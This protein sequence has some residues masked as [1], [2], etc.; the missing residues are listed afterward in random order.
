VVARVV[1]QR[2]FRLAASLGRQ[3]R[4]DCSTRTPQPPAMMGSDENLDDVSPMSDFYRAC[5]MRGMPLRY[6]RS[7][8]RYQRNTERYAHARRR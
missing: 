8:H 2:V 3:S 7:R 1:V 6:V 5:G 4:S